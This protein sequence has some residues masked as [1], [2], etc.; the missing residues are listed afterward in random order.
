MGVL[1]HSSDR[2]WEPLLFDL[3][4]S[5]ER[6]GRTKENKN[7]PKMS[8]LTKLAA[9]TWSTTLLMKML[10]WVLRNVADQKQFSVCSI[11]TKLTVSFK[12]VTIEKS[13]LIFLSS[14]T[15][16]S[17]DFWEKWQTK[18]E[19]QCKHSAGVVYFYLFVFCRVWDIS[20]DSIERQLIVESRSHIIKYQLIIIC[21][22]VPNPA[23]Y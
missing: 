20:G 10:I 13:L 22:S 18:S 17:S 5:A 16:R 11:I 21:L 4:L 23:R 3:P 12:R 14:E 1:A 8:A 6:R 19:W 7:A 15:C 9:A 2:W